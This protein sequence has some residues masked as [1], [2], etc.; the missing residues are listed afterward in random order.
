[1]ITKLRIV[2]AI[3]AAGALVA[4]LMTTNSGSVQSVSFAE[5]EAQYEPRGTE[6]PGQYVLSPMHLKVERLLKGVVQ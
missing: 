1:M 5:P 2:L 6:L 3:V 4:A